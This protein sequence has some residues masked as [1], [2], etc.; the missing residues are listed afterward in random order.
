MNILF[1]SHAANRSGAPLVLLELL[2]Y[3]RRETAHQ[4]TILCLREGPLSDE[5]ARVAD[6]LTPTAPFVRA[7]KIAAARRRIND[8]GFGPTGQLDTAA[9]ALERLNGRQS[10]AKARHLS[11]DFNLI[12]LNS[13]ASGD[14]LPALEPMFRSAPLL[15]HVHE[16]EWAIDGLGSAWNEVKKRSHGFVAVSEAVKTH[17]VEARGVVGE[18]IDTVHEFLDFDALQTDREAARIE[19]RARLRLPS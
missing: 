17:L 16:L 9:W 14:V 10:R 13:V 1:V 8:W 5:F 15:T 12:Y 19:L 4:A 7:S 3:L 18:K 6:V 2:R 11:A